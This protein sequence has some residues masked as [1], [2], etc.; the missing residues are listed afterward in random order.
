MVYSAD[1]SVVDSVICNGR[2]IMKHRVV[3]GE[4]QIIEEGRKCAAKLRAK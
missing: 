3:P 2:I 1:S 4:K